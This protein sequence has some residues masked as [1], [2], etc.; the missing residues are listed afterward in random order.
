MEVKR[1]RITYD[2]VAIDKNTSLDFILKCVL[3]AI[4][5]TVIP[6]TAEKWKF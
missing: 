3:N 2:Y 5:Y 4:H 6:M 1:L